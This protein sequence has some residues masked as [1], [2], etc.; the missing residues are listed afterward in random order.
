MDQQLADAAAYSPGRRSV[1]I[2]QMATLFCV[3]WLFWRSRPNKNNNKKK[4]SN[5]MS[6]DQM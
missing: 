2:H 4:S 5:I 3:K 6:S 1:C